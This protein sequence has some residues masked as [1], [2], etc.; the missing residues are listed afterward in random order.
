METKSV[1]VVL[2]S[3]NGEKYIAEQIDS[4]LSQQ[5]VNLKLLIRD[6]GSTD[7][8]LKIITDYKHTH[9]EKIY[10]IADKNVGFAKSFITATNQALKLFPNARYFAFADQDDYWLPNKLETGIDRLQ[11]F[12]QKIPALYCS[13]LSV[14]DANLNFIN[15]LR[16]QITIPLTKAQSLVYN[17]GVGCT[18]VFNRCA[19]DLLSNNFIPQC[20]YHDFYLFQI[21]RF[22]GNVVYDNDSYIQYRQHGKNQIGGHIGLLNNFANRFK[23]KS[24][25]RICQNEASAL[26]Y[27]IGDLL[28]AEDRLLISDFSM[29]HSSFIRRIKYFFSSKYNI[30]TNKFFTK[31]KI[32]LGTI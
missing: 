17:L 20:K 9:P 3:Y 29:L 25:D 12:N 31:L 15:K 18:M 30:P 32:L 19:A 23:F 7:S 13:N 1:V 26:L 4:I 5:N 11:S 2:S 24:L 10:L 22:C 6:D 8:T 27:G 14:V 16:P 21:C 28:S